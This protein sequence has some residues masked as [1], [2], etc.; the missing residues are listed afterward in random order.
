MGYVLFHLVSHSERATN[1]L[2]ECFHLQQTLFARTNHMIPPNQKEP[3][4]CPE[5]ERIKV[6]DKSFKDTT[7]ILLMNVSEEVFNGF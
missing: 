1:E 4:M 5:E 3:I 6:F 7:P 2:L